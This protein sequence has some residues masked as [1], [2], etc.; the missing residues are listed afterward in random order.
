MITVHRSRR[1]CER[2]GE[3]S[4]ETLHMAR[5]FKIRYG[6]GTKL[7]REQSS[8]R[9]YLMYFTNAAQAAIIFSLTNSSSIQ[10]FNS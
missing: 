2:R 4:R 9:S 8:N 6:Y 3:E 1:I 7:D 10:C 5:A